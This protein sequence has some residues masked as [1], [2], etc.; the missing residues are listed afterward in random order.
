MGWWEEIFRKKAEDW[1]FEPLAPAQVPDNLQHAAVQKESSYLSVYLKSARIVNVRQGL[2]KFYGVVNSFISVPYLSGTNAEFNV[3]TTPAFLKNVDSAHIDRVIQLDQR[4]LGPIP[5]RGGQLA[6]EIGLFSIKSVDLAA[7]YL[8][9]LETMSKQ[10]GVAF[11]NAALPFAEPLKTGI[12]LLVGGGDNA[13]LEIGLAS[14]SLDTRN[15]LFC[16]HASP[17]GKCPG[18][19][20]KSR[21][22]GLSVGGT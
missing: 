15:R 18:E 1:I 16:G 4:L 14:S 12:N 21:F 3:I 6:L 5:Y 13:L 9:V 17:Q 22:Y 20:I 11:I 7:P 2:S 10:A 19:R 8:E